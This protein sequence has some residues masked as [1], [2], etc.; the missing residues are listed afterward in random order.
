MF[1]CFKGARAGK[2]KIVQL[3]EQLSNVFALPED[4][5]PRDFSWVSGEDRYHPDAT[6]RRHHPFEI[7]A[8]FTGA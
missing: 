1:R 5:P 2:R 7:N 8:R 4:S 3:L 6:Q